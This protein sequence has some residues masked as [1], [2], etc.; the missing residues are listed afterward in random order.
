MPKT[1]PTAE[2]DMKSRKPIFCNSFFRHNNNPNIT[3]AASNLYHTINPS[4]NMI[5]FPKMAV[6]PA[7]KTA[8][9]NWMNA[10]FIFMDDCSMP[11]TGNTMISEISILG[12]QLKQIKTN[13]SIFARL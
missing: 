7:R 2:M 1:R 9:C 6:N 11:A 10:F 13:I 5:S 12:F 4:F 3:S 8:T